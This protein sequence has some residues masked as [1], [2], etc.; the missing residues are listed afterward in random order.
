MKQIK[1][2]TSLSNVRVGETPNYRLIAK[3]PKRIDE[4]EFLRRISVMMGQES[5]QSRF[6]LDAFR[7]VLFAALANNEAVD[8]NFLYA[9]LHVAGSLPTATEQPTKEGNPVK[10]R[11]FLKG[12]LMDALAAFEVVNDTLTVAAILYEVMQDGVDE[13]NRIESATARVVIN[14]SAIKIDPEQTDNGVWLE[15]PETG[16]KVADGTV[17]HSDSSTCHVTFPTLPETGKYKLV[18]ATRD[19]NDPTEYT[20]AKAVRNVKVIHEANA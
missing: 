16:L 5:I 12:E 20:L 7:D 11:V 8:L 17:I 9:K 19:G 2:K 18:I 15:D 3:E 6:W 14:G 1:I 4:R 13:L 10:P